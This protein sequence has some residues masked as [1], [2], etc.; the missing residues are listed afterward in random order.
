[1]TAQQHFASGGRIYFIALIFLI[2]TPALIRARIA[3][4]E[5]TAL[6]FACPVHSTEIWRSQPVPDDVSALRLP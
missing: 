1:M 6:Q 2:T 4:H 5:P 3:A